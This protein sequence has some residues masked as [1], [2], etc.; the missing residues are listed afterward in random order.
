MLTMLN[1]AGGVALVLYGI[2]VLRKG[3]DR[4]FGAHLARWLQRVSR[5]R[6]KG[7]LVGM[8]ISFLSP[9][10]TS[11][12][13]LG[14]QF[15]K[16][17]ILHFDQMLAVLLGASI[18]LTIELQLVSFDLNEQ[19][20]ILILIG[21]LGY[22]FVRRGMWRG[23]GQTL[24]GLG[25]IF[26]AIGVIKHGSAG[27]AGNEDV[28]QILSI[29]SRYPWIMLISGAVLTTMLQTSTA[30]IGLV[31]GLASAGVMGVEMALPF[32]I[33][34]N[35]GLALTTMIVGFSD[36]DSRRL[37]LGY[38]IMRLSLAVI[39]MLFLP[40]YSKVL[41]WTGED[42]ER[43][44]ANAHTLF[45]IL[46]VVVWI[47]PLPL[48]MRFLPRMVPDPPSAPSKFSPRYLDDSYLGSPALAFGQSLREILRMAGI[49]EGMLH[50]TW[51]AMRDKNLELCN[52][53]HERDDVVDALDKEI[54]RFLARAGKAA[55]SEEESS[56]QI[57]HLRF[58]GILETI[59]DIID[60]NL[61]QA[62]RKRIIKDRYFSQEGYEELH[63]AHQM[64]EENL[65]IAITAFA[66]RDSGLARVLLR[67]DEYLE[68]YDLELR[69]RHFE[70]LTAGVQESLETSSIH[71]D[72]LTYLRSINL[73]LTT[74]AH[75]ILQDDQPHDEKSGDSSLGMED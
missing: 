13:F 45:N 18:G 55:Y 73:H 22:Q 74:V 17:H 34:A 21:V 75:Q 35:V 56:T 64:V 58:S 8:G 53:I 27:V 48:M 44:I 23:V 65:H 24:L 69:K 14:V 41:Q 59:G 66:T 12:T 57:A 67:H 2:R 5:N 16:S 36:A 30:A 32:V 61:L 31:L 72:V 42:V 60:K 28:E 62:V 70:R 50:D 63:K 10:S 29:F 37:G 43:Q 52:D 15:V 6:W 49:V 33:G 38:L 26:M 11:I 9:S 7:C 68:E 71:L 46:L 40:L 4:L 1:I 3:L 54:K 20:P 39:L 19:A 25:L 47:G 51:I